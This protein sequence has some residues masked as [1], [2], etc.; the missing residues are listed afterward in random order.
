M[1]KPFKYKAFISYSHND[2]FVAKQLFNHLESFRLPKY[3]AV[4]YPH[5]KSTKKLGRI[6]R[7]REELSASDSLED[8][9]LSAINNSEFL[10]VLCSPSSAKSD[11]VDF[12]IQAF[13]DNNTA[14][15]ILCLIVSGQPDFTD[16]SRKVEQNCIPPSLCKLANDSG[17]TPLAADVRKEG[18]GLNLAFKKIVASMLGVELNKLMQREARR[19]Q[20]RVISVGFAGLIVAFVLSAL[21]INVKLAKNAEEQAKNLALEQ[22][23]RAEN[24]IDFMVDD[25]VVSKLQQLGRVDVIDAVVNELFTHYVHL[26]DNNLTPSEL[27]RK[28]RVFL[29]LG[30]VY[31]RKHDEDN[32][33]RMFDA[34]YSVTKKMLALYPQSTSAIYDHMHTL[35]W[36]GRYDLIMGKYSSA[37]EYWQERLILF[38]RMMALEGIEQRAY[39]ELA[40]VHV[41]LGWVLMERGK[42]REAL[43][44][45]KQGLAVRQWAAEN[46]DQTDLWFSNIAGAYHH[47]AWAEEFLGNIDNA[48]ANSLKSVEIHKDLWLKDQTDQ[49]AHSNLARSYRWLAESKYSAGDYEAAKEHLI[50]SLDHFGS[51]IT[52]EP[53]DADKQLQYCWS[54]IELNEVELKLGTYK[55]DSNILAKYCPNADDLI[56]VDHVKAY[57]RLL[58]YRA[59][60]VDIE[61]GLQNKPYD[62]KLRKSLAALTNKINDESPEVMSSS[63][64]KRIAMRHALAVLNA[65]QSFGKKTI[66]NIK[67]TIQ[68][69]EKSEQMK[70]PHIIEM[71]GIAKELLSLSINN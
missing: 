6:F 40:H 5:L 63:S 9:I 27:G 33:K 56:N 24:L 36:L 25:L 41:H 12:E 1:L 66:E 31:L 71:L 67:K 32:S 64:G 17:K 53:S 37:T 28:A 29:E 42:Y 69:A 14:A 19:L 47:I 13:L 15:N 45:F 62:Q 46:I 26:D 54:A 18:D 39:D 20:R 7:D 30:R 11:R 57:N 48:I 22:Q 21:A 50:K 60:L 10:I 3:L 58:G 61:Y 8:E 2:S 23:A 43:D 70:H 68:T 34:A 35:Y 52:F 51:I 44:L 4:D 49:R 38:D 16:M 59:A 55:P 65:E